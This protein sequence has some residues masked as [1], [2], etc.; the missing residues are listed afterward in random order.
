MAL[1]PPRALRALVTK[2]LVGECGACPA[3]ASLLIDDDD[4]DGDAHVDDDRGGEGDNDADDEG[5]GSR[6]TVCLDLLSPSYVRD[7]VL[8]I[9]AESLAPY[10]L[11]RGRRGS[12]RLS[13][14][15]PTVVV[16]RLVAVRAHCAILCARRRFAVE[17]EG[18]DGGAIRYRDAE[19]VRLLVGRRLR[20]SLRR[21]VSGLL[22]PPHDDDDDDKGWEEEK[23]EEAGRLGMHVLCLPTLTRAVVPTDGSQGGGDASASSSSSRRPL[24]PIPPSLESHM[25]ESIDE[26]ARRHRRALHPKRRFRGNDPT[27]KQGGDPRTNLELRARR[28]TGVAA[29]GADAGDNGS[30]K[31]RRTNGGNAVVDAA[32]ASSRCPVDGELLLLELVPWLEKDTVS[33]WIEAAAGGGGGIASDDDDLDWLIRWHRDASSPYRRSATPPGRDSVV[34]VASWRRPFHVGGT[35][36]KSRRDVSQ[37]PFYVAAGTKTAATTKESA[38]AT[39]GCVDEEKGGLNDVAK[40]AK[41]GPRNSMVRLGMSSVEEEICP[42]LAL[43]CG[44]IARGN[45]ERVPNGG[46]GDDDDEDFHDHDDGRR[47][48]ADNGGRGEI[49]YGMVKFHASGRED[50]DVRMLLPP[51][52]SRHA[53]G[54]AAGTATGRPFVCEVIDALRMPSDS[55]LRRAVDAINC[56]GESRRGEGGVRANNGDRYCGEIAKERDDVEWDEGGWPRTLARPSRYHGSNPRGV[57]V[58]SPLVLVP[59]SAFSTLQSQTEEKVKCYGCVCWT[60]VT[61]V[62]DLDLVQRLGCEHWDAG[63][64]DADA[65][66]DAAA[67]GGSTNSC[68]IYPLEIKQD[69]PLRVLHRRSSDVRTRCVLTLSARRISDHWFRLRMSTSAGT[70]VKEFVHGDC[71]RTRPSIGSMLG[72]RTDISELDCEGIIV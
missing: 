45:N 21:A 20:S 28:S 43:V 14:E 15:S 47:A 31:R 58:S 23:E 50:M 27:S 52:R 11:R 17:E 65:D 3:C 46:G 60:N 22:P 42:P 10:L 49:V 68:I 66:A 16:P 32:A 9:A 1:P 40:C 55:D 62:S 57:G 71:G 8:P 59:S 54:G 26:L 38:R 72:G 36:T 63:G 69:T 19:D 4:N 12:N 61:I 39:S 33:R 56:V 2:F 30:K 48:T 6:C 41:D 24:M 37:T 7:V 25:R 64:A 13:K 67:A 53:I 18:G 70:Y 35:Y 34:R 44:G 5:G 51:R 29:T